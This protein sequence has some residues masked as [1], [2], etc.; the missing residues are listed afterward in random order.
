MLI[1]LWSYFREIYGSC[2]FS[3]VFSKAGYRVALIARNADSLNEFASELNS[4][5]GEVQN[6]VHEVVFC[7]DLNIV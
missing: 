6:P 4:Q 7:T 2:G 3:R 5:G 1:H